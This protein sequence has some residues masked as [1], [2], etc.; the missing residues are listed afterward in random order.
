MGENNQKSNFFYLIETKEYPKEIIKLLK[1][2]NIP[3]EITK[4]RE[5]ESEYNDS[6]LDMDIK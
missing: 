3:F 5:L 2:R 4:C 6:D 1:E